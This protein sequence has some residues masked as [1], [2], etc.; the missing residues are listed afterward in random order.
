V[1][2]NKWTQ[3]FAI[4]SEQLVGWC[5][6]VP[7][8]YEGCRHVGHMGMGVIPSHR[9]KGIG[10]KLLST[11]IRDAFSKGIERIEMDVFSSNSSAIALYRKLG[12]QVEGT[13]MNAR[14]LDGVTDNFI[15]MGL[16]K[17][18]VEPVE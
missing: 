18:K 6:I 1:I 5:D 9:R 2:E 11:A 15:S 17:S 7:F 13:K 4:E 16:L 12:F 8:P 10:E 14:T 3:F